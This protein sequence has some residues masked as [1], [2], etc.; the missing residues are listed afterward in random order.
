MQIFTRTRQRAFY[1]LAGLGL[2]LGLITPQSALADAAALARGMA[3]AEARDFATL[4]AA[5][6]AQSDPVARDVLIWAK[7]RADQGGSF[8]EYRDFLARRPDWPGLAYLQRQGEAAIGD[9]D[10]P[11]AIIAYFNGQMPQTGAGIIALSRAL[12]AVGRLGEA[13]A[14]IVNGWRDLPLGAEAFEILA[15]DHAALLA[16]HHTSRLDNLLWLGQRGLAERMIPYVDG[17]WERLAQARIALRQGQSDGVNALIDAVPAPLNQDAGLAFE[18]FRWRMEAGNWDGARELLLARSGSA[19]GLG[20]PDQWADRRASLAR[21]V[22]RDGQLDLAYRLASAHFLTAQSAPENFAELEW[23][24]GYTAL[25]LGNAT[26]ARDHFIAMRSAVASPISLGRAYYWLGRAEEAL[27]NTTAARDAY[28]MGARYQSSFY[29]Q[30]AAERGGFAQDQGFLGRENFG[31]PRSA[32]FASSSV[33]QAAMALHRAGV[34]DLA[35][36]FLTHLTESLSREEAGALGQLA[37]DMGE[38]HY[39]VMIAKRAALAGHEIMPAYFPVTEL[40]QAN[41]GFDRAMVL[42]IAR[43]ESEFD[44]SV[45]SPAGA[46]GLMQVMPRTAR[47]QAGRMGLPFDEARLLSD[48]AYNARIG[49]GYLAHIAQDFGANPV[50]LAVAYN[51]GSSRARDWVARFGDPR[52]ADVDV[53]DWI[54]AVPFTETRNYIMR[55]AESLQIYEARL[56]GTLSQPRLTQIL[57]QR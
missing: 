33:L 54:E 40:A 26:R 15:R 4:R 37:L 44:P 57:K 39:A 43:R 25:R 30:L 49:A 19:E 2:G 29:G 56:S 38:P 6:D 10:D 16:P 48:P 3:A 28:G 11:T 51:A 14:V 23:L 1:L 9:T 13:D 24:S 20:R 27:G 42:S 21:D 12:R 34:K 8:A 32:R 18:R 17:A 7:L 52:S 45:T 35:E 41:L 31:D 5:F 50:L 47:A 36:R 22:M 46:L 53:I 55:V